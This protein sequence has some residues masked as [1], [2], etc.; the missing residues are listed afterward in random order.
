MI[1]FLI[2]SLT[3]I[4]GAGG[5]ILWLGEVE[6]S[7]PPP[8][9]LT[10]LCPGRPCYSSSFVFLFCWA[11]QK[12]ISLLASVSLPLFLL[13]LRPCLIHARMLELGLGF[14]AWTH[15]LAFM[16]WVDDGGSRP[17]AW[18]FIPVQSSSCSLRVFYRKLVVAKDTN[19]TPLIIIDINSFLSEGIQEPVRF[20]L[21]TKVRI[22]PQNERFWYFTKKPLVNLFSLK[23]KQVSW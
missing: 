21:D 14:C 22:F 11:K 2:W 23:L 6:R 13:F 12:H 17:A 18:S 5:H 20:V 15:F 1:S 4:L 10:Y 7:P 16:E 3:L 9:L 8:A 19:Q